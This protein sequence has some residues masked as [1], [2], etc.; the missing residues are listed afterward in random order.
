ME[1]YGIKISAPGI[2]VKTASGED[3]I[4]SSTKKSFKIGSVNHTT[5]TTDEDGVYVGTLVTHNLGFVPHT[6]IAVSLDGEYIL[7]PMYHPTTYVKFYA[8]TDSTKVVILFTDG[9]NPS[10]EL[11]IYYWLSE[12]ENLL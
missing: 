8:V 7:E 11:D 3:V 2:D 9:S 12:A 6:E 1:D 4:L 5:I 10:T